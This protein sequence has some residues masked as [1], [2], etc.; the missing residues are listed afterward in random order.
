MSKTSSPDN[1]ARAIDQ[2]EFRDTM[3][4][5]CTGV[6]I[7]TGAPDGVPAG[8]A[9]QSFVS[10]SL[11]PPLIALSPAKSSSS[12]PKLRAAGSLCINILSEKQQTLCNHF[13]RSGGDK[14]ADV[15][16]H[17]G[18]NGAPRLE[19]VIAHIECELRDEVEAGDHTIA[20]AEVGHIERTFD[21]AGPLLFFQGGY[22]GFAAFGDANG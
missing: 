6:V 16:W 13:A 8:F 15:V 12:W 3:S 4:Q 11:D 20:I 2:R 17:A 7:A 9:A 22:G 19:G 18:R 1:P 21:G 14:F 5:F 10:I